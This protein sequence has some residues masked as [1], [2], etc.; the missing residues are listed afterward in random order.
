MAFFRLQ[1]NVP[2]VYVNDSRDFQ[3]LCRLYDCVNNS[4]ESD[5][6]TM[7]NVLVSN[8]C[9]SVMLD[10]LATKVGFFTKRNV[11]NEEL[12][13]ILDAFPYILMYKGSRRAIEEAVN[14]FLKANKI[15]SGVFVEIINKTN[16][17]GVEPYTIRVGVEKSV[18]DLSVLEEIFRYILP[19]GYTVEYFFYNN[20]HE[21]ETY[22]DM[23]RA[24]VVIVPDN[25]N[26]SLKDD[27]YTE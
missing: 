20:V 26:S 6:D 2:A 25:V 24:F 13:Y 19:T 10:L 21:V 7:T 8:D 14:V 11:N 9:N 22:I 17:E 1:D 5:I 23:N 4:V 15:N 3:L 16:R 27:E 12:R 18:R